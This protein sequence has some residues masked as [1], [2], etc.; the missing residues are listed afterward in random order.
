MNYILGDIQTTSNLSTEPVTVSEA[1]SF[2][3]ITFSTDDTI[4]QGLIT[5]A[6]MLLEKFT[7]VSF[8]AKSYTVTMEVN[9]CWIDLPY[10]PVDSI[11]SV[12]QIEGIGSTEVL[13]SGTHFELIGGRLRI[14]R[15]G[16]ISIEYSTA[17]TVNEDLKTDIKRLVAFMYSNRG[18]QFEAEDT[19]RQFPD[20]NSLSAH[21][22]AKVVI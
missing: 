10:G 13:T 14:E 20:W 9:D 16:I 22:Y 21:Y 12:T 17:F 4:I 19:V 6:R 18:I 1:K 7:G 5:S 11:D 15:Q 8:G 2:M 3:K